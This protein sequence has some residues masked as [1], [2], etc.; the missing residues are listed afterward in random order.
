MPKCPK[1]GKAVAT[2]VKREGQT[3]TDY[4]CPVC[5]SP[6]AETSRRAGPSADLP[7]PAPSPPPGEDHALLLDYAEGRLDS[8][9]F[10][11]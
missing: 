2:V 5:V 6:P 11:Q 1:G 4:V 3:R 9:I 7:A 10:D 8:G